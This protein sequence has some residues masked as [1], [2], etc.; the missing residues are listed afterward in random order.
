[1]NA[2]DGAG[3]GGAGGYWN[4]ND[5]VQ[6][7]NTGGTGAIAGGAGGAPGSNGGSKS[8]AGGRTGW[9]GP[10]S[11]GIPRVGGGGGGGGGGATVHF[12]GE[13]ASG[14]GGGGGGGGAFGEGAGA[15]GAGANGVAV[16]TVLYQPQCTYTV[17][18]A[19]ATSP[20][21]GTTG[22]VT[23]TTAGGCAWSAWSTVSW[24]R[25]TSVSTASSSGTVNYQ[26]DA[27]ATAFARNAVLTIANQTVTLT[28]AGPWTITASGGGRNWADG[29]YASSCNQY[30]RPPL[31]YWYG[32]TTG[33]GVYT[34]D[35]DGAGPAAPFHV[36]CDMTT[37]GGG[38][39]E[40]A[41]V[42]SGTLDVTARMYSN[43]VNDL[44]STDYALACGRFGGLGSQVTMVMTIGSVRDYFMPTTDSDFCAMLTSHDKHRWSANPSGPFD[45]PLYYP[46]HLGGSGSMW[47]RDGRQYLSFWGADGDF[48]S[49][50]KA[51][52]C[53]EHSINYGPPASTVGWGLPFTLRVREPDYWY[54]NPGTTIVSTGA[55]RRW[56]DGTY[57]TSCKQYRLPP[58]GYT[59]AGMTGDGIYT[60]DPDA[61]GPGAP[62]DAYCDMTTDTGGWTEISRFTTGAQLITGATYT[63]GVNALGAGD[64]TLACGTAARLGADLTMM[65]TMGKVRDYFR[66]MSGNS[67]CDMLTSHS[68]H[69]WSATA[70]GDFVAPAYYSNHLGGSASG[71][72][73]DGRSFV[74]FWGSNG[75]GGT[76]NT[77]GCCSEHSSNYSP[78]ATS[79]G[80]GRPFALFVRETGLVAQSV[81]VSP[82]RVSLPRG[83]SY[84]LTAKAY[85]RNRLPL[86]N[87]GF[88]W[89][90][91]DTGVVSITST[92]NQSVTVSGV[93]RGSATLSAFADQGVTGFAT[94]DVVVPEDPPINT[95]IPSTLYGGNYLNSLASRDGR[96]RFVYQGDG[97]LVLYQGSTA[98]WS[99]QTFGPGWAA[100]QGDGNLVI[101]SSDGTP[102]WNSQTWG[103]PGAYLVA[104]NDGN[105][106][107]YAS[108][109]VALW[110]T[111]TAGSGGTG[112][113][114]SSDPGGTVGPCRF[115][116]APLIIQVSSSARSGSVA[117]ITAPGCGWTAAATVP[118]F[119]LSTSN[120]Q[121]VGTL[122]FNLETNPDTSSRDGWLI[123]SGSA[124]SVTVPIAQ[125]GRGQ[126]A[127][128]SGDFP[129][130]DDCE[131]PDPAAPCDP[132]V[133]NPWCGRGP[134]DPGNC[135]WREGDD[136][137]CRLWMGRFLSSSVVSCTQPIPPPPPPAWLIT[138]RC[139]SVTGAVGLTGAL[140]CYAFATEPGENY[141]IEG[142]EAN[143][144]PVGV[145]K[146]TVYTGM[147]LP[148]QF[149]DRVYYS[150][151][152]TATQIECVKQTAR[153]IDSQ[154]FPYCYLGPNSN[155]AIH[156]V[157]KY[158]GMPVSLPFLAIGSD[159][160]IAH[161]YYGRCGPP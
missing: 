150:E 73:G 138:V 43:G 143:F 48:G 39:T 44:G 57:A 120:G 47:P 105:V 32:G 38:W 83:S 154:Q 10:D 147:K 12:T 129:D 82:S 133:E 18:P 140:H 72:P 31:G 13:S 112:S 1:M 125:R 8:G 21:L 29:S 33:D 54:V 126:L 11:E 45:T 149:G 84:S 80:W 79:E 78:P 30:R 28:Q 110:S 49:T 130:D 65:L 50:V 37:D 114:G 98:L 3:G 107:I 34:V 16:L 81:G 131:P 135:P 56:S 141:T 77:S 124:G 134:E 103:H 109:G 15:G 123:V 19:S 87:A 67:L 41:R 61:A 108:N 94:I 160:P 60:I 97:N 59:Y 4:S 136:N 68:K 27:N 85:E 24:V 53:S 157:M 23:L 102:K 69:L 6:Y 104:Q 93:D 91:S 17:S 7:G 128:R 161:G 75:E 139:R 76:G 66:P 70:A 5:D 119:V 100:M 58:T 36:Y 111:N 89:Q 155:S 22:T 9:N 115:F 132:D 74:S 151:W 116:V 127:V 153:E 20:V 137:L 106:V 86:Y 145:L 158:C 64:Y 118:W 51:G 117:I 2:P 156:T 26:I 71:W 52:C 121:G 90:S 46:N 42:S 35:T 55:S 92:N 152:T 146:M 122:T 63:A 144:R 159:D 99:T 148:N 62:F 40:I 101:Y 95:G 142:Y 113:G 14:Y 25:I 88:T 96:F